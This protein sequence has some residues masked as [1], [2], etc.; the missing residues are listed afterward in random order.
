MEKSRQHLSDHSDTSEYFNR[1][2]VSLTAPQPT[3]SNTIILNIKFLR[4]TSAYASDGIPLCFLKDSS[5]VIVTHLTC[6][7]NASIVTGSF[8]SLW[9]HAIVIPIFKTGHVNESKDYLPI[10]L[11]PIISKVLEK[12]I[13]KQRLSHMEGNHLLSNTQHGFGASLSTDSAL[14]TLSDKLYE[15]IDTKHI[16]LT[17]FEN[18]RKHLTV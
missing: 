2:H 15:N 14:L 6:I 3:D 9:K 12:V 18:Y 8:P 11:L 4:N 7:L 1:Q 5:P 10:S 13:S 17:I 16:S